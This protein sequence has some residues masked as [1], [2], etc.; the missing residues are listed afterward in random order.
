[1]GVISVI[2]T[3]FVLECHHKDD[4]PPVPRWLTK[5]QATG[6]LYHLRLQVEYT[7][8]VIYKAGNEPTPY[9]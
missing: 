7:H 9:W 5:V 6:K 3:V 2:M 4:S 8:F 1:M